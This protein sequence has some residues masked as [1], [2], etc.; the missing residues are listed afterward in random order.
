MAELHSQVSLRHSQA[1]RQTMDGRLLPRQ[2]TLNQIQD[3]I[4]A[5]THQI[6]DDTQGFFAKGREFES[7]GDA[8]T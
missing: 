1:R 7:V 5:G 6:D 8:H 3:G 2:Q 4:A